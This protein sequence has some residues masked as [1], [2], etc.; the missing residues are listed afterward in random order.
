MRCRHE[1]EVRELHHRPDHPVLRQRVE[2]CALQLVPGIRALQQRHCAQE[3]EQVRAGE[4]GLIGQDARDDLQ[5]RAARDD[6]LFLEEAEPLSRGGTEDAAAVEDHAAG[7]CEVVV[8]DAP[9]LDELLGHGVAG[10]EEDACGDRLGE[11]GARGQLRLVPVEASI[12]DWAIVSRS[13]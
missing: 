11:D 1:L 2:V 3:T 5:V 9:L 10:R 13:E 12:S 8:L 4:D 7:A 6:N